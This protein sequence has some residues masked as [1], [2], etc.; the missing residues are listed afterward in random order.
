[1]QSVLGRLARHRHRALGHLVDGAR[2]DVR[3]RDAGLAPADQ[4]AQPDLDRLG[5]FGLFKRPAADVDAERPAFDRD[6][7]RGP[8]AGAA[9]GGQQGRGQRFKPVGHPRS[10]PIRS[11]PAPNARPADAQARG[12]RAIGPPAWLRTAPVFMAGPARYWRR[13]PL[14]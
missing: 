4:H 2:R 8:G 9:G 3:G 5:A 6:R 13:W 10:R 11:S 12:P 7:I 1:M 14:A